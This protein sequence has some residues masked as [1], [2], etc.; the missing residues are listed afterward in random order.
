VSNYPRLSQIAYTKSYPLAEA[1]TGGAH[2]ARDRF[3]VIGDERKR[4]TGVDA[5]GKFHTDLPV[6]HLWD[7]QRTHQYDV[8][9]VGDRCQE[10]AIALATRWNAWDKAGEGEKIVADQQRILKRRYG[11]AKLLYAR[12]LVEN[13][14]KHLFRQTGVEAAS[15]GVDIRVV[16]DVALALDGPLAHLNAE[17]V[18]FR[19]TFDGDEWDTPYVVQA[20]EARD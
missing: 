2:H 12:S 16:V 1:F 4:G 6:V 14:S 20:T 7:Q 15:A 8:G 3:Y 9:Y 13:G 5:E 11:L 17:I 18:R 19:D 10:R